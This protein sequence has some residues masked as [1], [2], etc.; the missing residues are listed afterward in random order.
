MDTTMV[1]RDGRALGFAEYGD[2]GGKPVFFFHAAGSSRLHHP[3][4]SLLRDVGIRFISTDRPGH[5]LS[6]PQPGRRLLDWPDDVQQLADQLG[7]DRFFV[8]GW[9][10]GG[11]YA[12]ACAHEMPGRVAAGAI[13]G[14]LAPPERPHPYR[15][16]PLANRVLMFG[17]RRCRPL[18]CLLRRLA[19]ATIQGDD[20]GDG[21]RI[22]ST[23]P[24]VDR[25]LL[26]GPGERR[27]FVQDIREGYRQGWRGPADDDVLINRPWGFCL[28]DVAARIDIWQGAMDR[29][30]P[31]WQARY[32]HD[33]IPHSRL[34]IWPDLG[35][36]G[37]LARWEEVL[38]RLV[39]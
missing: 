39:E 6:D 13:S 1:L 34:S 35:H 33:R 24:A 21:A 9:S 37:L 27:L 12:L 10:S 32:Q 26:H 28:E 36:L 16:M 2:P 3:G 19:R 22:V 14:G 11:P 31:A 7:I 23:F 4:D 25:D 8:A 5:G 18:V 20:Q 38:A 30:V 29:N 17:G 15:G